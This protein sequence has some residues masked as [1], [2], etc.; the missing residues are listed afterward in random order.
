MPITQIPKGREM[1]FRKK[2]MTRRMFL[3]EFSFW[4]SASTDGHLEFGSASWWWFMES[5]DPITDTCG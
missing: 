5:S 4:N 1:E 3:A 2:K